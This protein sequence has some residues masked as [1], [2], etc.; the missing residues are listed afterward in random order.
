MLIDDTIN[1]IALYVDGK[2]YHKLTRVSNMFHIILRKHNRISPDVKIHDLTSGENSDNVR[3]VRKKQ[4]F[5]SKASLEYLYDH[6]RDY[7]DILIK[8]INMMHKKDTSYEYTINCFKY[9]E[10]I[11]LYCNKYFHKINKMSL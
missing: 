9:F 10:Y 6:K 2:T 11:L 4:K 3:I 8:T 5:I 7:F 1:I